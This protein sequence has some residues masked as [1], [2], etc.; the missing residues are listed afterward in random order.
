MGADFR[1]L[2]AIDLQN[3][4]DELLAEAERYARALNA[5]VDIIHV[6]P[7]DPAFVGYT[8]TDQFEQHT[9]DDKARGFRSEHERTQTIAA[10]LQSNGLRLGHA[11][12]V[13]G[14]ILETIL[15]H[16]RKLDSN[17]LMLGSHHHNAL[18]RLWYGDAAVDAAK[19]APCSLLV[20]PV[21]TR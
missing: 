6:A 19:Q 15:D 17:L 12:T 9:R 16:A 14:P 20:V 8:K 13:Q 1:I 5:V 21:E 4:T 3:G 18:Y 7:P 2:V 10:K 11:L